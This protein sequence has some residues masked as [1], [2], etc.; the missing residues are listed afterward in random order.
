MV[1]TSYIPRCC[2]CELGPTKCEKPGACYDHVYIGELSAMLA[3]N[4]MFRLIPRKTMSMTES[5]VMLIGWF[6]EV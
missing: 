1:I 5:C 4:I 2:V 6:P 3:K